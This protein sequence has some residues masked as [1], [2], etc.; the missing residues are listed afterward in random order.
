MAERKIILATNIAETSLTIDGVTAVIDSGLARIA[1]YDPQRGFDRLELKRIS[2]ASATQRAG[3]AGRT[4]PGKCI[5]LWSEREQRG[6]PRFAVPEIHRVDVCSAVLALHSWGIADVLAFR[7]YEAP[8]PDRVVH[9]QRL[10][11]TLGALESGSG[12]ITRIGEQLLELPVHPRLARLLIAAGQEGRIAEGTTVAALLSEKDITVRANTSVTQNNQRRPPSERGPSDL[13]PRMDLL[14]EAEKARFSPNLRQRGIDPIAARQ[15]AR[16]RDELI[17]MASRLG[18]AIRKERPSE[19]HESL[20]QW[21]ILAFPDRIVRRRGSEE[22]GVMVGGRGVRLGRESIV[23][24]SE[25]FLAIN[26]REERRR[27]TLELQVNL[28]SIVRLEWLER[29]VP[30]LFRCER[31]TFF[32]AARERVVDSTRIWYEDLLLRED[33]SEPRDFQEASRVL[34]ATVS[35]QAAPYFFDDPVSAA[36]LR[37]YEFIKQSLWEL[38]WPEFDDDVFAELIELICQGK[39]KVEEI[40]RA[41]KIPYLEGRLNRAQSRELARGA[42]TTLELPSGRPVKLRYDPDQPPVLSV[43]VQ[44]LFG[45][46][47]TPRV[48][49]GTVPVLL[50]ILG[51]NRRPVQIT[52]DLKSF[53]TN[54]YHQVRK[55]LRGRYPKHRWPEDPLS[56]AASPQPRQK[57]EPS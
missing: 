42:P 32:D 14:S 13:L 40:R 51:P 37:R 36:W 26:P 41:D 48:A 21:L 4:G 20:L 49:R 39:T 28:A 44:E 30:Y 1:N 57:T 8:E 56:E 5:R 15:V 7:W 12:R 45:W 54:T 47:E 2:Q 33:A 6:R 35:A 27:G 50:E 16:I 31:T 17:R 24:N 52:S 46:Q 53:W 22:T 38:E 18:I 11:T 25:L 55:D 10:L 29:L 3:R 9:A 43:R 23:R 19:D 34:S